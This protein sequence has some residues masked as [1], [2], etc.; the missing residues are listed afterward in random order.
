MDCTYLNHVWENNVDHFNGQIYHTN[1]VM[2][3]FY[4]DLLEENFDSFWYSYAP[5]ILWI[6]LGG[7]AWQIYVD[8]L[9][10]GWGNSPL[11]MQLPSHEC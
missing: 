9:G 8:L 11:Q 2:I 5:Q 10:S 3:I 1:F 4:S 7:Y 6:S